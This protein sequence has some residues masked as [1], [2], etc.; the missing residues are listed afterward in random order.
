ML[1]SAVISVRNLISV[2]LL[3]LLCGN[4][5]A[6]EADT[7]EK[8]ILVLGD[9]ISAGFGIPLQQGWVALLGKELQ[10]SGARVTLINASISGE[11]TSG[12]LNRL[13]Q[14]LQ[15]HQPQLLILEL[16]GN[17]GLRGTPVKV[18]KNNLQRMIS[19]TTQTKGDILLVGM[20]IPPNYGRKYSNLFREIF[21]T[22]ASKNATRLVPFLLEDVATKPAMMQPDGIHPTAAAQP[23][24]MQQVLPEVQ[25]WLSP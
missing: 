5:L 18:I 16:G 20:Q 21:P 13:P 15:Q 24:M 11:T 7:P 2:L 6:A 14:L 9:S 10:R 3:T 1:L 22:L 12:G 8:T 4:S 25:S 19:L 17:D 23:L